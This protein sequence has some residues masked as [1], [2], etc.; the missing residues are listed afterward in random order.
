MKL[1]RGINFGGYLSQ[2]N[3]SITHYENFIRK[4][5]VKNVA[6][7]GFDHIR[8][9]IDCEVL[10]KP[11]GTDYLEGI[12]FVDQFIDWCKEYKLDVVLDLHKAYGYDF[13][14][15]GN[16]EQNNL[17]TDDALKERFLNLW[18]KMAKRY[19]QIN[20]VAFELLNEV[21][22]EENAD[23]WNSLIKQTVTAIRAYAPDT[24][25]IYG[26]IQWNSARTLKLL[27]K[28]SDDNIIYTF[29][30]YEPLIFTHQKAYWVPNMPMDKTIIYPASMEYYREVS[31]LIGDKGKDTTVSQ[32]DTMGTEFLIDIVKEAVDAAKSAGVRLYCGEFGV[33]DQAP[34]EDTLRWF[35]DVFNVFEQFNIH[36]AVWTYKNMDFGVIDEHYKPISDELFNVMTKNLN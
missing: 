18:I 32:T 17:F 1:Y 30:M 5:D 8:L 36:C 31:S 7:L 25:I 19:G 20:H 29:H 15:A 12:A 34:V 3:H 14:D 35:K 13:N 33:I 2:C 23:L 21:V 9:P 6:S 28:P 22:E 16:A 11:D 10:E 4:E 24:P 27:D 26:G